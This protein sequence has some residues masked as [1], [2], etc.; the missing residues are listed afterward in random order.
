NYQD[1]RLMMG[2][3]VSI[4]VYDGD[5]SNVQVQQAVEKAF[6]RMRQIELKTS[7]QIHESELAKL[8]R[9]A[10]LRP[11]KV[12]ADLYQVLQQ[13]V[14]IGELSRGAFD[15]TIGVE[16]DLWNFDPDNPTIPTKEEIDKLLPLVNFRLISLEDSSVYLP[17]PGMKI[18]LGG[19]A[20]GFAVDAAISVLQQ[21]GVTDALVDAGGDLRT[22]AS[23]WTA[24]KRRVWIR[25]PRK[26]DGFFG[27][28]PLDSG[29]VATSGDYQQY[30]ILN[31]VRFHHIL[32]PRTGLPARDCVSVTILADNTMDADALATAVFVLG[33][34]KGLN[35]I[36]SL[37]AVEG[38]I[39]FLKQKNQLGYLVS[40]GLR[41]KLVVVD[42]SCN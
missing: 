23:A 12:S 10:G 27:Y 15:V 1:T 21:N 33:P 4:S 22:I 5:K 31:G 13:A 30:L 24:G 18:N 25:H 3:Y 32:N 40:S 2:T 19:I 8:N 41:Q 26:S 28:F 14:K 42:E 39:I 35:L 17:F 34:Q 38:V 16:T 7:A 20:K 36:E 37:D 9:A 6:E 11:M 29:S